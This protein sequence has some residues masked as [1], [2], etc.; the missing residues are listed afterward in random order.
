VLWVNTTGWVKLFDRLDKRVQ[1]IKA[2]KEYQGTEEYK[3]EFGQI[4]CLRDY[5]LLNKRSAEKARSQ[6]PIC[7]PA[8]DPMERCI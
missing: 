6:I 1:H 8:E 3:R 2:W 7:E 5:R 4:Q